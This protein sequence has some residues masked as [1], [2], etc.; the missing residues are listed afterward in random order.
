[1]HVYGNESSKITNAC[2]VQRKQKRYMRTYRLSLTPSIRRSLIGNPL[3]VQC[4][5]DDLMWDR[6]SDVEWTHIGEWNA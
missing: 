6:D 2:I 5:S 3:N 4:W 1:M